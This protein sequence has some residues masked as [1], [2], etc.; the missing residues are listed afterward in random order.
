M[1]I[2]YSTLSIL[3]L[4]FLGVAFWFS[5]VEKSNLEKRTELE[6]QTA[7]KRFQ[8]LKDKKYNVYVKEQNGYNG[9]D[10]FFEVRLCWWDK[11][12]EHGELLSGQ[13]EPLT[14]FYKKK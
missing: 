11:L 12:G 9:N 14:R 13:D 3:A 2:I 8:A 1:K 5:N 6:N 10:D 4:F 7:I